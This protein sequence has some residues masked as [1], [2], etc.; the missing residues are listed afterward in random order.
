[1]KIFTLFLLK[2]DVFS[3]GGVIRTGPL[4]TDSVLL[5]VCLF[6]FNGD[7][8]KKLHICPLWFLV[9]PWMARMPVSCALAY[10][11]LWQDRK[12]LVDRIVSSFY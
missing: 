12:L 5:F 2:L 4:K 1:M 8:Q 10:F 3:R 11:Y 6:V 9:T 7:G